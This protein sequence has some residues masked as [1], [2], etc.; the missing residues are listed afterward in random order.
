M[1]DFNYF[2]DRT[3]G[4]YS[5]MLYGGYTKEEALYN[6]HHILHFFDIKYGEMV[7]NNFLDSFEE[8]V[9]NEFNEI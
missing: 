7:I 4:M 2:M 5:D 8:V 1:F 3:I 9:K 6:I